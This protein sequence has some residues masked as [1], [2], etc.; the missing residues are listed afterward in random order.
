[1]Y[2]LSAEMV[3]SDCDV[4]RIISCCYNCM[5][6]PYMRHYFIITCICY[7]EIFKFRRVTET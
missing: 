5:L 2:V 7:I 6:T 1:M 4:W 3:N